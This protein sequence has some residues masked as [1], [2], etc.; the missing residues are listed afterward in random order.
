MSV[1]LIRKRI[2]AIVKG[3]NPE[4]TDLAYLHIFGHA[5]NVKRNFTS[6]KVRRKGNINAKNKKI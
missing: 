4:P 1:L 5:G 3:K 6:L 2:V